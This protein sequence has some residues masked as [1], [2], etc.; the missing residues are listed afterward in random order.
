MTPGQKK[1]LDRIILM[2][3]LKIIVPSIAVAAV[4]FGTIAWIMTAQT[5]RIDATLEH[6]KV[7]GHVVG[8]ARLTGRRGGF[9]V[10]VKLDDG[11]E[12]DA[13]SGVPQPPY[14]GEAV[15]LDAATHASGRV[16]YSV[17]RLVN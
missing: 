2:H 8:A 9:K 17:V 5:A 15:E 11:R 16:T 3:R 10:H 12:V 13:M 1:Q 4:M 14:A 7:A 6:H